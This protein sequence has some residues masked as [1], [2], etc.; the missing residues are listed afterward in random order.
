MDVKEVKRLLLYLL[1]SMLSGTVAAQTFSA[2]VVDARTGQ[3]LPFASVY[4]GP[5]IATITNA[6]GEFSVSC[7]SATMLRISYVSYRQ[8]TL[9]A[10]QM[11]ARIGLATMDI[12]LQEVTVMPIAPLIRK[13]TKETLRQLQKNRKKKANF[14]YRQTSFQDSTCYEFAEAFI[15]GR[16]AVWLREL[17]LTNGRYAAIKSDSTQQYSYYNNFYTNSEIEIASGSKDYPKD[18]A[19]MPLARFYKYFYDVDYEVIRDDSTCLFAIHFKPKRHVRRNILDVTIY[20]DEQTLHLRKLE[21]VSR[22]QVI[23][24][25]EGAIGKNKLK[26][27]LIPSECAFIVNMTEERGFLEVQSVF[28]SECHQLGEKFVETRS[29]LYN[30]GDNYMPPGESGK[31]KKKKK[32]KG[33]QMEFYGN[34][35]NTITEQGYDHRFWRNNPVVLRTPLEQQ[36]MELF[37]R[38]NLFGLFR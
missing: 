16:S 19:L 8:Q 1:L 24:H 29:I 2:K 35:H 38:D 20:V 10:G 7:D 6:E 25:T 32:E 31:E 4:G 13:V 22:N 23:L 18:N 34:L 9:R 21:G 11:P 14:F 33:Q 15:T 12:E 5:G 36:V 30:V 37:E 17:N 3:P 28:A 26:R 27:W